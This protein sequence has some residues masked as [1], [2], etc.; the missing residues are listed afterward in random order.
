MKRF[1]TPTIPI[2]FNINHSD[3]EHI[4]FLFKLDKDM[5]SQTLFTRKY[6]DNVGYDEGSDLYTIELTAEESGRLPEGII[7]MDTRVVMADEKIPATPI[8]EL[9]V[10]PTLFNSADKCE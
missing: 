1:T 5:N 2:K 6:P 8:V 4:D 7:F 9:R 10:S 3:I